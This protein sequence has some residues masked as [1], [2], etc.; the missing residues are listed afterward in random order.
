[1]RGR[2]PKL[3]RKQIEEEVGRVLEVVALGGYESRQATQL[4][5]GQQQRLA[6]ARALVAKPSLLLLDEPLSNL[7]AKLREKMRFELKRLQR[8]V[9]ITSIYVT[10]DQSEALA[11]SHD[12][13]VMDQ[14][15]IVQVGS[16][17]DIYDRP[18]NDFVAEFVGTTNFVS[19]QVLSRHADPAGYVI[20]TPC[21][22]LV[23]P[24]A[25]SLSIGDTVTIS[26]RP[27]DVHVSHQAVPGLNVGAAV[28]D[29]HM[30]LGF[31]QDLELR[32]GGARLEARVHPS[33]TI[34]AG[35]P[36]HVRIDPDR[37]VLCK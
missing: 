1:V 6:L 20:E 16:P 30:F 34:A 36:V 13:A 15:R 33:L 9:G 23:V 28:V 21:G 27:E 14:G 7:D 17:R 31:C 10:H 5:G 19:G 8:E 37:C 25:D 24:T 29:T 32:W 26:I 4:S 2:E 18:S 11:L 35:A 22:K 12:I 3:A